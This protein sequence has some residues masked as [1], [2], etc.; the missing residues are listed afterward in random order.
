MKQYEA[1]IKVM[2][3]NDGYA[4]VGQLYQDVLKVP[5]CVWKTKTPYASIR[6]IVQDNR[7]FF[8]IRPGLWA[9]KN[10]KENV[11][12][13]LEIASKVPKKQELFS[14][15]Y[16]QGLL[17]QI[18]NMRD[19]DTFVPHQDKNKKFL[20]TPLKKMVSLE[21]IF[22]FTYSRLVKKAGTIDVSWFNARQLPHAFFE[23]EHTSGIYKSL[24]KFMYLQDFN[25]GFSIVAD[26]VRYEE[27]LSIFNESIFDPIRGRVEFCDYEKIAEFHTKLH[28]FNKVRDVF[29]F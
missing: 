18:G 17:V 7:F 20:N 29:P 26:K 1:V 23:V 21:N 11:L 2:E 6:R 22:E 12:R 3:E 27:F 14:H 24:I 9:L 5:G 13:K 4:T 10:Q 28:A 15:T 8:K 19:F 25:T 16:Y